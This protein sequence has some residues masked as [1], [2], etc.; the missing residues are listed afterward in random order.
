MVKNGMIKTYL[1]HV[2]QDI[3]GVDSYV[4]DLLSVQMEESGI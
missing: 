2:K 1:A 4:K 3:D